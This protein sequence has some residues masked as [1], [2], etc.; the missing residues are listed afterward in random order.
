MAFEKYKFSRLQPPY[1][2][3]EKEEGIIDWSYMLKPKIFWKI[4]SISWVFFFQQYESDSRVKWL[5]GSKEPSH[6]A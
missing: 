3:E 5:S 6:S 1:P 4:L 2:R